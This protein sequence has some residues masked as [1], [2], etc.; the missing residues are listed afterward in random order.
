IDP[1]NANIMY[2]GTGEGFP[3]SRD[4]FDFD[5]NYGVRGAG[6]FKSTDGGVTWNQLVSTDPTNAVNSV[7][8]GAGATCP[9]F[10]VNRLAVAPDGS[11]ILAAT[12]NGIWRSTDAGAT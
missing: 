5:A 11:A 8:C 2:A 1:T 10:N 6:I 7:V 4:S 9:W 12:A 3:A